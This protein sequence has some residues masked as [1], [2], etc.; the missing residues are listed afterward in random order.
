[1]RRWAAAGVRPF[2]AYLLHR[3]GVDRTPLP[4]ELSQQVGDAILLR[5]P[6]RAIAKSRERR[7][8]GSNGTL[9]VGAR[10]PE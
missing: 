3:P 2:V 8:T 9:Q 1:M 6:P 10:Y 4:L 5:I 7:P